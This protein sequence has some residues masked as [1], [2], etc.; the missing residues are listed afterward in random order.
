M[1][2]CCGSESF[3]QFRLNLNERISRF[4]GKAYSKSSGKN[5]SHHT[6]LV[7]LDGWLRSYTFD[8]IEYSHMLP[9]DFHSRSSNLF[10]RL[11][12]N[13]KLP[14]NLFTKRKI[15]RRWN[16]DFW[17]FFGLKRCSHP[18]WTCKVFVLRDN[19]ERER[20]GRRPKPNET[21]HSST[22]TFGMLLQTP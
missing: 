9:M 16:V 22:Y 20:K 13:F 15:L 8:G 3:L 17:V 12:V 5:C 19:G 4:N 18:F 14:I 2:E 21:A 11:V 1:L 10:W 6:N 7:C